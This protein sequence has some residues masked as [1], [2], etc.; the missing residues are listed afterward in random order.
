MTAPF[1]GFDYQP[2]A[3]TARAGLYEA[4]SVLTDVTGTDPRITGGATIW[5]TNCGPSG[6]WPSELCPPPP[7]SPKEGDRPGNAYFAPTTAWGWDECGNLAAGQENIDRA[8]HNLAVNEP[9]YVESAFAAKILADAGTAAAAVSFVDAVAQLE[10]GLASDGQI[11]AIHASPYWTAVGFVTN[12]LRWQGSKLTTQR[13][14]P[15]A[16]GGGYTTT[17][18]NTIVATG[19][20]FVWRGPVTTAEANDTQHNRRVALAERTVLAAYEPCHIA[21]VNVPALTA[22]GGTGGGGTGGTLYPAP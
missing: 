18:G 3:V 21:A 2:P 14:T 13:G 20:V 11:G 7:A 8:K 6:T 16:D 15:W 12:L 4:A 9:L 17:L 22:G 10:A 19:N 5:P 1:P